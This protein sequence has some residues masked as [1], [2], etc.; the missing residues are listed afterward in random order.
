M[1]IAVI[2]RSTNV[3]DIDGRNMTDA[4]HFQITNHVAPAWNARTAQFKYVPTNRDDRLESGWWKVYLLDD[5]DTAGALGY[6][7]EDEH[8]VPYGKV[9][10]KISL[11]YGTVSSVLSHEVIELFLDPPCNRFAIDFN[12]GILYAVEG[13]DPVENDSYDVGGIEVSNFIMPAWFDLTPQSGDHFDW[14]GNLTAPFTMT[15]GGYLIYMQGGEEKSRFQLKVGPEVPAWKKE[16]KWH[17]AAR[18][19]RKL[20]ELKRISGSVIT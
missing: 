13:G 7:D 16:L 20:N 5:A 9:F 19:V 6:H 14:L 2:N 3:S 1:K 18:T 8:G 11:Q 4:I 12:T 15:R 17:P 10:T